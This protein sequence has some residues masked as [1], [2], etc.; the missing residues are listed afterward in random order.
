MVFSLL[1]DFLHIIFNF[2]KFL[3]LD[4][5]GYVSTQILYLVE[6]KF[7]GTIFREGFD[8]KKLE[9]FAKGGE[10]PSLKIVIFLQKDKAIPSGLNY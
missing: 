3:M 7:F 10:L 1:L 5:L 9:V 2:L 6:N 4:I 8:K